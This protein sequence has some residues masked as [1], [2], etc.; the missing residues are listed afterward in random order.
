MNN[1]FCT[2]IYRI[3]FSK[4]RK[5]TKNIY[6]TID[7]FDQFSVAVDA[8]TIFILVSQLKFHFERQWLLNKLIFI[9]L[10]FHGNKVVKCETQLS[11][12]L[13]SDGFY[14]RARDITAP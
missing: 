2:T 6:F 14:V 5:L 13:L 9:D 8:L 7:S 4:E 1:L 12:I 11:Q 10:C 3:L